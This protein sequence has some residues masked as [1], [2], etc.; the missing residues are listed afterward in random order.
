MRIR[1]LA[2]SL[3]TLAVLVSIARVLAAESSRVHLPL[4]RDSRPPSVHTA[5]STPTTTSTAT[6]TM[7]LTPTQTPTQTPTVTN[8]PVQE[9]SIAGDVSLRPEYAYS[10]GSICTPRNDLMDGKPEWR[11]TIP[12]SHFPASGVDKFIYPYVGEVL[13]KSEASEATLDVPILADTA[14][15]VLRF[16]RQAVPSGNYTVSAYVFYKHPLDVPQVGARLYAVQDITVNF[17][18]GSEVE[19]ELMLR[20]L[21]NTCALPIG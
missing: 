14:T 11:D 16:A 15:G 18:A 20:L 19:L 6:A 10:D 2:T 8:T 3:L 5:T 1:T 7:T 21:G 17:T 9:W 13:L 12:P 4:M